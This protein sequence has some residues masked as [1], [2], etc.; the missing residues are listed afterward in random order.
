MIKGFMIHVTHTA[1]KMKFSIKDFSLNVTKSAGTYV[2]GHIYRRNPLL[3]VFHVNSKKNMFKIKKKVIWKLITFSRGKY[4]DS[5]L[6][7]CFQFKNTLWFYFLDLA[8]EVFITLP[9]KE[10]LTKF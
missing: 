8:I 4:Q 1:Q 2:F 7:S 5:Y 6:V 10:I 9:S 3:S